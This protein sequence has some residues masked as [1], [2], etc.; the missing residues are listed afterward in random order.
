MP[1]SPPR[2]QDAPSA[3]VSHQRTSTHP[4]CERENA[5]YSNLALRAAHVEQKHCITQEGFLEKVTSEQEL[6][7]PSRGSS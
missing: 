3:L 1:L 6:S 7:T 5:H 2:W 4:Q